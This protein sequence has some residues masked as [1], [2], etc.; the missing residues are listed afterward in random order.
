M[1]CKFICQRKPLLILLQG[2]SG[3]GKSTLSALLGTKLSGLGNLGSARVSS[4]TVMSTDSV[5]HV[6][7]NY[8]AQEDEPVL[9][10]SSY[11]C[12]KVLENDPLYAQMDRQQ[13]NLEGY[14]LQCEAVQ[15]HLKNVIADH[16]VRQHKSLIV[17]GVHLNPP[18]IEE[19]HNTYP[20]QCIAFLICVENPNNHKERFFVRSKKQN[21]NPSDNKYI[22]NYQNIQEI[23]GMLINYARQSELITVVNNVNVDKSYAKIHDAILACM[24]K[25][26]E[27]NHELKFN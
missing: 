5:R 1:A 22:S 26:V 6:M 14:R 2:T 9:F 13:R 3:T 19:M 24:S 7:R 18:F 15:R 27:N 25:Q 20:N 17:E 8:L 12:G 10:S 23:Q 16:I 11:E 4:L 21:V